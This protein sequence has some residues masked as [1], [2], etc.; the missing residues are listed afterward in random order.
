MKTIQGWK[1]IKVVTLWRDTNVYLCKDNPNQTIKLKPNQKRSQAL[2]IITN[3]LILPYSEQSIA[4][5]LRLAFA[6][7][8]PML[9]E[10]MG[11]DAHSKHQNSRPVSN[12]DQIDEPIR[13][14]WTSIRGINKSTEET[15][16]RKENTVPGRFDRFP[17]EGSWAA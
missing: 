16:S 4:L 14:V 13:Q 17:I 10:K 9:Q 3:T 1:H 11:Y 8:R 15:R 2:A 7:K 5:H 6:S 12:T